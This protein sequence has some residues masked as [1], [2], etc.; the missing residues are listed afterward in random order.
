[1]F[2]QVT[3]SLFFCIGVLYFVHVAG[4]TVFRAGGCLVLYGDVVM[5]CVD[6]CRGE[7]KLDDACFLSVKLFC[8][9]Q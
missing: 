5:A 8:E 7:Q 6:K 4:D 9:S 1:M 3:G 2:I